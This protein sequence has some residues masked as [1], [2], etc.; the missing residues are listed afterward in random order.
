MPPDLLG[1]VAAPAGIVFGREMKV[2]AMIRTAGRRTESRPGPEGV[3]LPGNPSA[4]FCRAWTSGGDRGGRSRHAEGE[5]VRAR[6]NRRRRSAHGRHFNR[7][8]SAIDA[9]ARFLGPEDEAV[10]RPVGIA[11]VRPTLALTPRR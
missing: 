2:R 4:R 10:G 8:T 11:I 5:G 7:I 1:V 9:L 3:W 6:R